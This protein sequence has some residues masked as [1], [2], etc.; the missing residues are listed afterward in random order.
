VGRI[1]IVCK[2]CFLLRNRI[3]EHLT[4]RAIDEFEA[5]QFGT[6]AQE[7]ELASAIEF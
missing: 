6:F 4:G 5:E 7:L 3:E 2:L 1:H